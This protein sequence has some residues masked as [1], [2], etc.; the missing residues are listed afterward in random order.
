MSEWNEQARD[1]LVRF[2]ARLPWLSSGDTDEAENDIRAALARIAE[3]E[4]AQAT[5][6]ARVVGEGE[7]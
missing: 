5:D 7:E 1:R 2:V 3:L 6:S 4:A